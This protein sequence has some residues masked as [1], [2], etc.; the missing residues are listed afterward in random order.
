MLYELYRVEGF[1][2][3]WCPASY[4][5]FGSSAGSMIQRDPTG[6]SA[7]LIRGGLALPGDLTTAISDGK[8]VSVSPAL[9]K[10][11]LH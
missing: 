10:V 6:T 4:A 11:Q 5:G 1:G 3:E 8:N 7:T 2:V 9:K